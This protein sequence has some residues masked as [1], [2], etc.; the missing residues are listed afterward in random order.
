[1]IVRGSAAA[2]A[3]LFY[4]VTLCRSAAAKSI[5]AEAIQTRKLEQMMNKL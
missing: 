2:S 3:V 1:M 4:L 5:A